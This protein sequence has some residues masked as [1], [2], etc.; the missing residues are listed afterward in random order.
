MNAHQLAGNSTIIGP[1][2]EN[3][4]LMELRKQ[5]GWSETRPSFYH[6]RTHGGE[7]VDVVLEDSAGRL[8][9]VEVKASASIGLSRR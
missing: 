6:F 8:V 5:A 9:A 2:L 1:L 4:V 3:F 7:E